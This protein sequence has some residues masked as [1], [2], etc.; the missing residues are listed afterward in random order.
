MKPLHLMTRKELEKEATRI[1]AEADARMPVRH[2]EDTSTHVSWQL[3]PVAVEWQCADAYEISSTFADLSGARLVSRFEL[4]GW[5]RVE[6][7]A[8]YNRKVREQEPARAR[9]WRESERAARRDPIRGERI[10]ARERVTKRR[11]RKRVKA[12]RELFSEAA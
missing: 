5:R 6:V 3:T 12:W 7:K 8:A 10:K 9:Q 4:A 1:I 2:V 11:S